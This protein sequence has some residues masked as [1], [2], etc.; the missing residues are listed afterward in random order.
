[1]QEQIE[2][3]LSSYWAS[4][5]VEAQARSFMAEFAR[6][7]QGQPLSR[8]EASDLETYI[9][10][11]GNSPAT[12]RKKANMVRK[13]YEV[14]GVPL[15][16][17]GDAVLR[18]RVPRKLKWWLDRE[19]EARVHRWL[20]NAASNSGS[21]RARSRYRLVS[22][23]VRWSRLTGL[24]IEESLRLS[25][26]SL[27]G[28]GSS[29]PSVKIDGTKTEGS[30]A[31]L[32]LSSAAALVARQVLS[33]TKSTSPSAPLWPCSYATLKETWWEIRAGVGL[34][35]NATLKALRR[36]YAR[37]RTI[38]KGVPTEVLRAMMRHKDI[39]T[40]IGYLELTGGYNT[41]ELRKWA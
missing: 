11:L 3:A 25:R 10:G 27:L 15:P 5:R 14:S 2:Q 33:L 12:V 40:T 26:G 32:P 41:E 20:R 21:P 18:P 16:E 24:R 36:S 1:M 8:L 29:R 30:Q 13:L 19:T 9:Q 28:I 4:R 31:T 7:M 6:T 22:L 38:K 17:G 35:E 34:P 23:Y 39:R 37:E